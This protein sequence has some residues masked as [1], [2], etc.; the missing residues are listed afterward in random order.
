LLDL[1]KKELEAAGVRSNRIFADMAVGSIIE[2]EGLNLVK[3]KVE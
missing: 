3:T 1:Q 2:R